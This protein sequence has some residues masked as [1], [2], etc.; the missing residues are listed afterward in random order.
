MPSSP[1][2]CEVAHHLQT[3]KMGNSKEIS[4][5][6]LDH[7]GDADL[8]RLWFYLLYGQSCVINYASTVY[9][10]IC[11][12]FPSIFVE[13]ISINEFEY[14]VEVYSDITAEYISDNELIL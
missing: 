7:V 13:Y 12:T 5:S 4:F 2:R 3:H 14:T 6:R 8:L 1:C 11:V 9:G 10:S